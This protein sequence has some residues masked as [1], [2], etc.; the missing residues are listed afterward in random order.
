[1]NK[2]FLLSAYASYTEGS[3]LIVIDSIEEYIRLFKEYHAKKLNE[4][5]KHSRFDKKFDKV[6]EKNDSEWRTVINDYFKVEY[7]YEKN[8]K[9]IYEFEISTGIEY[10]KEGLGKGNF[11][12][13]IKI[14]NH[15]EESK[16]DHWFIV[17][18][19]LSDLP[20]GTHYYG[21][22]CS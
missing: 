3:M 20:K 8:N 6:T 14:L 13:N 2:T 4:L 12:E 5:I 7:E 22:Y 17:E 11:A 15:N 9:S 18:E 1:M 19:F 21:D 16:Q 10:I